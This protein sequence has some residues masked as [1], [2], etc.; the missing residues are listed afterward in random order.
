MIEFFKELRRRK[1]WLFGGIYL[2]MAWVLFEVAMALE[3]TLGLPG[4]VDQ[5]ALV[6]LGLGFPV[7]LLLAWAQDSGTSAANPTK[8]GSAA[9]TAG[10]AADLSGHS[11]IFFCISSR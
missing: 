2:A 5:V 1:V 8:T 11:E 10:S 6:L 4:W 3:A 9:P 7:A